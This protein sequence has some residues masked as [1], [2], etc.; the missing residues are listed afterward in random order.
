MQ[1]P[2]FKTQTVKSVSDLGTLAKA[3]QTLVRNF[4]IWIIF[5]FENK[6]ISFNEF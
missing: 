1:I 4:P 3:S 2:L 6:K 5:V